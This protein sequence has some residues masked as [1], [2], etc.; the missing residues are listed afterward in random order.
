MNSTFYDRVAKIFGGYHS[1]IRIETECRAGDPEQVFLKKL[2]EHQ[3]ATANVLDV[4]CADGRFTISVAPYFKSITAIDASRGMLA[5]ARKNQHLDEV[6][7]VY[8]RYQ[9]LHTLKVKQRFNV[10]Y[11]RRG[12]TDYPVFFQILKS[13]GFYIE[14]NIGE[15]DAQ[16]LKETFG[17][18]QNFGEWRSSFLS[19]T[20]RQLQYL[21]FTVLYA[22]NFHCLE[23]YASYQ[24]IEL[25]LRGVPI[26]ED[27]DSNKDRSHLKQYVVS[28]TNKRGIVLARH[29]YVLVA[30]K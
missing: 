22:R 25:F 7:N 26:F 16:L 12:P 1:N 11:C 24:D 3:R 28:H 21:G 10:V 5:A 8:F 23:Y 27:F 30:R 19:Q 9:N 15:H 2:L 6:I 14:I 18:G 17:R 29:R 20:K 13:H 4:G